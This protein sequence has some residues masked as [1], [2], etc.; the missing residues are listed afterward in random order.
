MISAFLRLGVRP[1]FGAT[2]DFVKAGRLE[3]SQTRGDDRCRRSGS[4]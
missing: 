1:Q 3:S 2:V 4:V